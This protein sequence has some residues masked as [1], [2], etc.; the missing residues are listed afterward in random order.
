MLSRFFHSFKNS[1]YFKPEAFMAGV[2]SLEASKTSEV[3]LYIVGAILLCIPL[4][5]YILSKFKKVEEEE[6][7]N[8]TLDSDGVVKQVLFK[9]KENQAHFDLVCTRLG[10]KQ[11]HIEAFFIP[12]E[13]EEGMVLHY[14]E[15]NSDP[16]LKPADQHS[17]EKI[18]SSQEQFSYSYVILYIPEGNVTV[19]W[20]DAPIEVYFE[21]N[22]RGQGTLY[23]FAS[24]VQKIFKIGGKTYLQII[25]PTV[26]SD[27]Q[28]K[29]EVRIEPEPDTIE[30][31]SIWLYPKYSH[32]LPAKMSEL[33]KAMGT[34]HPDGDSDFRIINISATG[35]RVRFLRDDLEKLPFDVEKHVEAC[36]FLS[37]KT[38]HERS[39]R[40]M[41]W[42]MCECKGLAPCQDEDCVDVRFTFTHWEQIFEQ[43]SNI[44]WKTA[45]NVHRVPPLLHWL[46]AST[47][48][49]TKEN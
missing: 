38:T 39:K 48:A 21:L 2:V 43:T 40:M 20:D 34:F 42:L 8:F 24:F 17:D 46:M 47:S 5:L 14:L 28:S 1:K 41:L 12:N 49:Q 35:A 30:V 7:F 13:Q 27:S 32:F 9:A 44:Q 37:I 6:C 23:H 16:N 29:E 36:L 18:C 22:A 11:R 15:E 19:G 4:L 31:A 26:L 10:I 25:H 33:G 3:V 45:T